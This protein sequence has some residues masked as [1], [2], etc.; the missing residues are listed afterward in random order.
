MRAHSV[1]FVGVVS[2]RAVV[3][4]P[5]WLP[6][7]VFPINKLPL[8]CCHTAYVARSREVI[9]IIVATHRAS[10]ARGRCFVDDKSGVAAVFALEPRGY[11]VWVRGMGPVRPF[12]FLSLL[13]GISKPKLI[14]IRKDLEGLHGLFRDVRTNIKGHR[15]QTW[16]VPLPNCPGRSEAGRACEW[17]FGLRPTVQIHQRVSRG[18]HISSEPLFKSDGP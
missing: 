5:L 14:L 2:A 15:P 6:G 12:D 10:V 8:S 18:W 13:Q 4:P 7:F 9:A 3:T 17:A 16:Q 11:R 1:I